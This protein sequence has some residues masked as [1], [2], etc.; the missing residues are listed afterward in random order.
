[1]ILTK[2]IVFVFLC[3]ALCIC[4][5]CKAQE[6]DNKIH[7]KGE[8]PDTVRY[9]ISPAVADSTSGVPEAK[10]S[11]F[12]GFID[13][14]SS[15]F[16]VDT[17]KRRKVSFLAVPEFSYS[18]EDGLGL[19][20]TARMYI[21]NYKPAV[22][23]RIKRQSY[24]DLSADFTFKGNMSV[25]IRPVTY[26][27]NDRLLVKGYFGLGHYP[28][29]FWAIG[30]DTTDD[31]SEE[32]DK[33]TTILRISTYWEW[34]RNIYIGVGL[35][36]NDYGVSDVKEGGM[37][38][39]GTITGSSGTVSSGFSLHYLYDRRD[40]QF[41]PLDGLYLSVDGYFNAKFMGSSENY[42][43]YL[44]DIRYYVPIAST[45]VIAFNFYSQMSTGHVPFQDMAQLSNWVHSRGYST[46]RYNDRNLMSVQAEYR[47]YFGRFGLAA[48]A[49]T[50]NVGPTPLKALKMDKP[51]FGGGLRFKP[52]KNQRM[53]FRA[54]IGVTTRGDT[55]IYLG[56]DELF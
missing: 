9:G 30:P 42:T 56:L 47:Y 35:H 5:I 48:F 32:Y 17:T 6:R 13:S 7:S 3:C 31:Q 20:F 10:K 26:F 14:V 46:G 29:T 16:E 54:D 4:H 34:F 40:H 23:G 25:S 38:E 21:N 37:L 44:V 22:I 24:V 55:Q 19:G 43:K 39:P 15:L 28:S 49:S 12:I 52:F 8:A 50:A 11:K 45:Q 51:T 41:V 2:Y 1:M 33:R 18:E 53:Y 36:Y 27:M